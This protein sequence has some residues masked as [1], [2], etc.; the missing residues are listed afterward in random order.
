MNKIGNFM[1]VIIRD[2]T[3]NG[4][5]RVFSSFLAILGGGDK[6]DLHFPPTINIFLLLHGL[7]RLIVLR[8]QKGTRGTFY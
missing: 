4:I 2:E 7:I 3:Q 5:L 8:K 6:N 1:K